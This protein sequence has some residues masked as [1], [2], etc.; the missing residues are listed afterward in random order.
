MHATLSTGGRSQAQ[1]LQL[2]QSPDSILS[3]GS[4][5]GQFECCRIGRIQ[6]NF[7]LAEGLQMLML[8][9]DSRSPQQTVGQYEALTTRNQSG[10]YCTFSLFVF[11]LFSSFA[12]SGASSFL[13]TYYSLSFSKLHVWLAVIV[14]SIPALSRHRWASL[15]LFLFFPRV[16][17]PRPPRT[18]RQSA[19]LG[20]NCNQGEREKRQPCE[21]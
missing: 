1:R 11:L 18:D 13:P 5:G 10:A 6:S 7:G 2:N 4:F 9:E 16:Y 20:W 17:L 15:S 8:H 19:A 12:R 3:P 14:E 21:R